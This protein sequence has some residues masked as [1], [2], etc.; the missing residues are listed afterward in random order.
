[1]KLIKL[2]KLTIHNFK[3]IKD[4]EI[5]F[6]GNNA[7]ISGMNA[8][9]KS[10]IAD[11]YFWLLTGKNTAGDTKFAV[12]P[13][14]SKGYELRDCIT[15][16]EA[17]ILVNGNTIILKKEQCENIS[18]KDRET[19][20]P[21]DIANK[22]RNYYIDGSPISTEYAFNSFV[23]E[24]IAT[25]DVLK[26]LTNLNFFVTQKSDKQRE[27]L[28]RLVSSD[29]TVIKGYDDIK[30]LIVNLT[31]EQKLKGLKEE[32]KAIEK[33]LELIPNLIDENCKYL[34]DR[35]ADYDRHIVTKEKE[36]ANII[37]KRNEG[38]SSEEIKNIA[39]E[40]N[41]KT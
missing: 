36:L 11:S 22:T 20:R 14:D 18:K 21:Q 28:T 29:L 25:E 38:Y 41:L 34:D 30:H 9:G 31:P 35:Y 23:A 27:W 10:T 32:L 17:V 39:K 3:C 6:N 15:S 8:S 4:M 12:T 26:Y 13:L 37:C 7:V 2:Q 19:I 5:T 24:K 33:R 40:I 1:M 16:V